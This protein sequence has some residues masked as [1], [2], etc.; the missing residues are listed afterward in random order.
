MEKLHK[1][2]SYSPNT[3][4][5]E[6]ESVVVYHRHY[7]GQI[8]PFHITKVAYSKLNG[9]EGICYG[10]TPWGPFCRLKIYNFRVISYKIIRDSKTVE[11]ILEDL[12]T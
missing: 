2:C 6:L 5:G 8:I 1:N 12:T 11:E 4:L 10:R 3:R 7:T 9:G